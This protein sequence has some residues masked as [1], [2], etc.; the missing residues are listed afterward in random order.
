MSKWQVCY[1]PQQQL[2]KGYVFTGVCDSVHR[3]GCLPQCMLGYTRLGRYTPRSLQ[4]T[5]RILLE[6]FLVLCSFATLFTVEQIYW[7]GC[8]YLKTLHVKAGTCFP[9]W[10]E[11]LQKITFVVA[12]HIFT[13][14]HSSCL[15]VMFSQ[16]C[17]STGGRY[18]RGGGRYNLP[19][20]TDN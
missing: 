11:L 20:G 8:T 12:L 18:P 3:R 7:P 9:R 17:L 14:R 1:R 15:K 10:K 13:A 16:T 4:R 19:P 5:V 2:R 6:C